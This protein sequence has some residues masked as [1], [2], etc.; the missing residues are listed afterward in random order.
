EK[1]DRL[2]PPDGHERTLKIRLPE[3]ARSGRVVVAL[4][5]ARKR[6]G[7][8]RVYDGADV[9]IERGQRVALVGPNGAGKTT[10]PKRLAGVLPLDGGERRVGHNVR[11]GYFAQAHA[12]MLDDPH[13]VPAAVMGAASVEAAPH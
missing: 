2:R 9:L 3:A 8:V 7:A 5:G 4:E 1:M 13:T 10:L 12:E 6:Y 11:L